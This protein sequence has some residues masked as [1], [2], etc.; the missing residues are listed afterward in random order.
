LVF[1]LSLPFWLLGAVTER[2]L[3]PGL[4]MSALAFLC[5]VTAAAV[6]VHR[7]DGTAGVIRLLK[8]AFDYHRIHPKIWYAPILLLM[9]GVMVLSYGVMCV[10]GVPLPAP[11]FS[12]LAAVGLFLGFFLGG[13]GEELGWSGYIIDRLQRRWTALQASVLLGV[14]WATWHIIPL[15]QARRPWPWIAGWCLSTVALRIL[16]VW[17]YNNTDSSVFGTILLH[18]MSNLGWLLF[19]NQGSHY[20]PRVTGPIIAVAAAVVTV[21]W[22]PRTLARSRNALS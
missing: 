19:P 12:A 1:A 15:V 4:P 5:P 22:G 18:A 6:L 14:V 7:H 9:P 13:A 2:H 21:L 11:H 10:M 16:I 20:D 17:I 3:L 8:R